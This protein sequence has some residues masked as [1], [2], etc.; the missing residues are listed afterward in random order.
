LELA[1]FASSLRP[2]LKLKKDTSGNLTAN[3]VNPPHRYDES[4]INREEKRGFVPIDLP[5]QVH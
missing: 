1:S 5:V 2:R 3:E 4:P